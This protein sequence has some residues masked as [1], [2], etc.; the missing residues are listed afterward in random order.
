MHYNYARDYDPVTG[1]YVESDPVG[2]AAGVNTYAYV[3]SNPVGRADPRG[4][5]DCTYSITAHSMNCTPTFPWN[6]PFSSPNYVSGNNDPSKGSCND[7]QNNPAR[8]NVS[9]Q[10][11]IPTG[12]YSIG[13]LRFLLSVAGR[14]NL[15]P[16]QP[17]GRSD[18]EIHGCANPS[19]CSEG[20]IGATTNR[21][22]NLL[23]Y[24]LGLEE[25]FNTLT[26][27]P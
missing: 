11:P 17:N 4:L 24:D 8:T 12:T 14:R 21:D 15:T 23:N 13:P 2:L 10:G 16:S 9:W 27:L 7:C 3:R 19:R 18:L 5:Y 25:G 1:R 26:V 20:C 6:P 22:R